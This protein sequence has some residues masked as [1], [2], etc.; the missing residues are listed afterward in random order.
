MYPEKLYCILQVYLGQTF[1]E[2]NDFCIWGSFYMMLVHE[3]SSQSIKIAS[4]HPSLLG[5]SDGVTRAAPLYG[6]FRA[7]LAVSRHIITDKP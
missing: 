1:P 7:N 5:Y 2:F 3:L 6:N 4:E